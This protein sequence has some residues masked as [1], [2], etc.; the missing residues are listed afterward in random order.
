VLP[1]IGII[2]T[3]PVLQAQ[4]LSRLIEAAGGRG[5]VFP[6][7]EII[8][9]MPDPADQA[10]IRAVDMAIFISVNAVACGLRY[11]S[12]PHDLPLAAIGNAT[13][14]AL[15]RAGYRNISVPAQG[16]DSGALLA[17]PA[18]RDVDGK[19]IAIFRGVGGRETLRDTLRQR[20]AKVEYIE[21]YIRRRPDVAPDV[22]SS[23]LARDDI[24][25][26][27]VLSRETLENFCS[28]IG[29]MGIA[30]LRHKPLFAPHPAILEG[31]RIVGF[32]EGILTEF[33]DAKLLVALGQRFRQE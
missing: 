7:L 22:V 6:A 25:A 14:A 33:G 10:K 28:M 29:D 2:L 13:A 15:Q 20:G 23:L 11:A 16:A 9:R 4:E 26:I 24:A 19:R 30:L 31:A 3:R 8:P 5:I 27:Q 12:L 1:G 18:L 21:C 32:S 17:T